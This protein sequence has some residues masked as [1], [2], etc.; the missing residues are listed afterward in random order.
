MTGA[1][2]D[3][4]LARAYAALTGATVVLIGIGGLLL[5]NESLFDVLNI[6]RAED[7]IHLLSGGTLLAAGLLVRDE[8]VVRG[9]VGVVGVAYLA[10]GLLGFVAPRLFGLVPHGYDT[11][12]DNL[13]HL[14]LGVLG[15]AIGFVI[16]SR[17]AP[18]TVR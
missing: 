12:L 8:R 15:V 4:T 13:I 3:R 10:V 16:G 9:V 6:D 5:G 11:V 18:F 17:S 14:T 2:G 7:A 1:Q